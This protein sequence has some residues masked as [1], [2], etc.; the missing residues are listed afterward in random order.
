MNLRVIKKEIE[1]CLGAF[2][3]DC[4]LFAA[5]NPGCDTDEVN[6]IAEEAVELYNALRDE[7]NN[8]PEEL[9]PKTSPKH[10]HRDKVELAAEKAELRKK[11]SAYYDGIRKELIEKLDEL[12]GKLSEAV[13]HKAPKKAEEKPAPAKKTAPKKAAPKAAAKE[14]AEKPAEEKAEEA[15]VK[16][17]A[18]KKAAPKAPKADGE[19]TPDEKSSAEK[20]PAA[21]KAP[22]K[23]KEAAE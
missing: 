19:K 9:R 22:A 20:K 2:I 13:T 3:D 21:K 16:K 15:P 10:Q 1:Y 23:K 17:T 12:N 7:V 11:H 4:T 14:V 18:P 5:L 6:A 8:L